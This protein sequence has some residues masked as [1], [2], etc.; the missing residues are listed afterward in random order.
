MEMNGKSAPVDEGGIAE[1]SLFH[2]KE[3]D[4][5]NEQAEENL[6]NPGAQDAIPKKQDPKR[7]F[8]QVRAILRKNA[9]EDAEAKLRAGEGK[10][11]A[12]RKVDQEDL[13][14]KLT[15]ASRLAEKAGLLELTKKMEEARLAEDAQ[16]GKVHELTELK[17]AEEAR[18][19]EEAKLADAELAAVKQLNEIRRKRDE[20]NRAAVEAGL[21]KSKEN[22]QARLD[23]NKNK[24]VEERKERLQR[25]AEMRAATRQKLLEQ[26]A[27]VEEGRIAA[28]KKTTATDKNLTPECKVSEELVVDQP[29]PAEI[30][31]QEGVKTKKKVT[32]SDISAAFEENDSEVEDQKRLD[33]EKWKSSMDRAEEQRSKWATHFNITDRI[34][35]RK[36]PVELAKL[37][38]EEPMVTPVKVK[39]GPAETPQKLADH[40]NAP[41][42]NVYHAAVKV[43][44]DHSA[45]LAKI[46]AMCAQRDDSHAQPAPSSPDASTPAADPAVTLGGPVQ[47]VDTANDKNS[48]DDAASET[49][50]LAILAK[51]ASIPAQHTSHAQ[52]ASSSPDASTPTADPAV[53]LGGPVQP[54]DAAND[55]NGV[56]DAASET[57]DLIT[58]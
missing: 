11:L 30:L 16:V 31:P 45:I 6:H 4:T 57:S 53:T 34:T 15:K 20:Q 54:V 52:P 40:V 21:A 55:E 13:A 37:S 26:R 1:Q 18:E 35:D 9:S 56:D 41:D 10:D 36:K 17:R 33:I 23:H 51:I 46:A 22:F 27:Q 7:Q 38:D 58:F 50:D 25:R 44:I 24:L 42:D 12:T 8:A 48:I 5:G 14:Q 19:A 2:A 3:S 47:P 43:E 29:K 32:L 39:V 49:S 28:A